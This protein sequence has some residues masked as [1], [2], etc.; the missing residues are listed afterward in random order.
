M[1]KESDTGREGAFGWRD[2]V[3]AALCV[4]VGVLLAVL[5][6]IVWWFKL[7]SPVWIADYDDLLYLSVASRAYHDHPA[8]LSDPASV[9]DRAVIFDWLEFA[10]GILLAKVLRW[11]P[12]GINLA[13]RIWAGLTIALGWYLIVRHYVRR[14]WI[15]MALVILL[16]TDIGITS[17]HMLVRPTEVAVKLASGHPGSLFTTFPQFHFQWRVITPSLSQAFLLLHLWLLARARVQPT[18][19]RLAWSGV[20][21]GLLFYIYFYFWTAA[22]LAL[23]LALALDA[24]HRRV[25]FHTGWIG[26]LIGLPTIVV[27]W[28]LKQSSPPDWLHRTDNFLPIARFSEF[29]FPR[30]ALLL[31]VV[32][33]VWVWFRRRDLIYLWALATAGLMLLN[34]QVLSGLQIQNFHWT[35]VWGLCFSLLFL[36]LVAGELF[37]RKVVSRPLIWG[38]SVL[39]LLEGAGGVWFRVEEATRTRESLELGT[40][41]RQY[42]AQRLSPSTVRLV[43]NS[44]VAG[45]PRFVGLAVVLENLRPLEHYSA[46]Y[47]PSIDNGERDRRLALDGY[48]RDLDSRAF[49]AEQLKVLRSGWGP[50]SRDKNL[51]TERVASRLASFDAILANPSAA[52]DQFAVR[53][54]ALAATQAPPAYLSSG[55]HRLQDGPFWQIWER[56]D[57]PDVLPDRPSAPL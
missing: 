40:A 6:H 22:G 48:L 9:E 8:Y 46:L 2:L 5:P 44:V 19:P 47:S 45:N 35:Y 53:Y 37:D 55:W 38:L 29:L 23:L 12:L 51:R 33:L 39:C 50:W 11:G 41:L 54:V 43:P 24:G 49:A 7:G 3:A 56:L 52:L 32:G 15:T 27:R 16:L 14:V 34:H 30:V 57:H 21:F 17:A 42:Q 25:Y 36:L 31:S 28:L 26:T 13:W 4:V 1:A 18:W 10:P 20:G